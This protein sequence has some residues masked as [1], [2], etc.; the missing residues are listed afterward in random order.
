MYNK[1]EKCIMG[2]GPYISNYT[3][4]LNSLNYIFNNRSKANSCGF[5]MDS[6]RIFLRILSDSGGI[7][8][9]IISIASS[10]GCHFDTECTDSKCPLLVVLSA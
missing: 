9:G 3:K 6:S 1:L 2:Q 10:L 8:G 4:Y 5:Q 7:P